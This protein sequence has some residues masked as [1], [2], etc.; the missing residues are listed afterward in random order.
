MDINTLVSFIF[1]FQK[2]KNNVTSCTTAYIK[3][4]IIGK[5]KLFQPSMKNFRHNIPQF[6]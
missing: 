1:I 3:L 2:G 6:K 5:I 4:M